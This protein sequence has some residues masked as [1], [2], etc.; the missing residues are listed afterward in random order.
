MKRLLL[1]SAALIVCADNAV[2]AAYFAGEKAPTPLTQDEIVIR[3]SNPEGAIRTFNIEPHFKYRVAV[4]PSAVRIDEYRLLPNNELVFSMESQSS[5]I[6]N[7]GLE[8]DVGGGQVQT[9]TNEDVGFGISRTNRFDIAP[10]RV[11]GTL[12][13]EGIALF[14]DEAVGFEDSWLDVKLDNF[15][16]SVSV[17]PRG[18]ITTSSDQPLQL[19]YVLESVSMLVE[20]LQF[21]SRS[22]DFD[23]SNSIAGSDLLLWQ[24]EE[25]S[26]LDQADL[27]NWNFAYGQTNQPL[28]ETSIPEPSA[29]LL[30]LSLTPALLAHRPLI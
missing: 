24:Q 13:F 25:E 21:L 19:G 6:V 10:V 7:S 20:S 8:F 27:D 3:I 1:W 4:L 17:S 11:T 5:W 29:A 26:W 15:P 18:S 16:E 2:Q 22:A 30:L 9:Y 12:F 14:L 23:G 28:A